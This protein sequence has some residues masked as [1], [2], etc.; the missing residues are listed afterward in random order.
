MDITTQKAAE[1]AKSRL[2]AIVTSSE[3]GIIGKTLDGIV[4]DWNQG[5][6]R[7]FGYTAEE[8]IGQT[9]GILLPSGQEDE[10]LKILE[11]LKRG[12]RIERY[13]T[14]RRRKDGAII[15]VSPDHL[16]GIRRC[17]PPARGIENRARRHRPTPRAGRAAGA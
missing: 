17:R 3:D 5:A 7:I 16:A 1:R 13:D 2:A 14:H 8:M 4:T 12:E 11:R 9:I 10:M 6:Q 15:D